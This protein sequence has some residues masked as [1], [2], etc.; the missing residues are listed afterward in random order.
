MKKDFFKIKSSR[1]IPGSNTK[2]IHETEDGR[3][4]IGPPSLRASVGGKVFAEITDHPDQN[5]HY[6]IITIIDILKPD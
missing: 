4:I 5:G 1:Q 3:T 6:H 2:M